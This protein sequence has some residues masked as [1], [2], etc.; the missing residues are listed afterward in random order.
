MK[1]RL[2]WAL[3]LLSVVCIVSRSQT[4][5]TEYIVVLKPGASISNV[6]SA[7]N[8][9]SVRQISGTSVYL[10]ALAGDDKNGNT[11][12]K[13]QQDKSVDSAEYNVRIK[14][15]STQPAAL[16]PSLVQQM[17]SLLDGYTLTNFYGTTVLQSYASQ[18]ALGITHVND[19]RNIS[20]GAGT[21]IAYIDTGADFYHPAIA[22]WLDP[23]AD[24]LFNTS[25]SELDGLS[26]Q[27]ASLL[28]QQ[29]A[30]LLDQRFS[31]MLDQAM[32]SLLDGGNNL[33]DFPPDFGHGTLVAGILHV[34]APGA[35][36]VP[37]KA[38]DAYGNTTAYSIVQ[39][40]YLARDMGVDVLNM[41]FSTTQYSTT[42]RKALIDAH[43]AGVAIVASAG[44]DATNKA[45]Y[46]AAYPNVIGV[47]ATD[48]NDKL[49]SFSNYGQAV[50]VAAPGA[51]VVSTVPG[52]RYAAAWG[53]SFSAPVVSGELALLASARGHGNSGSSIAVNTSDSIDSV[54]PG[55][56]GQLGTGRI[57][58]QR[59][60]TKGN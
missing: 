6:N 7:S 48:F 29:M 58:A 17:A 3:I 54:N 27:M 2:I 49:A 37:I 38:F 13:F 33:A 35:R 46:P 20:T 53:T 14:L 59:A 50:S 47:A 10:I 43:A 45:Y 21:H 52:G 12:K 19:V 26:Q 34:V 56:A 25:A 41:S 30:S 28:D 1:K 11:L 39:A 32:A 44:N 36:I 42:L 57:N 55:F 23:G 31:F 24:V 15:N 22:P 9:T 8:A 16:D 51:F 60:L 5:T 18:A 40:V 4:T